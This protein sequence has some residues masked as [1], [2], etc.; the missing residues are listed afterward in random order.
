[1]T[2]TALMLREPA[3]PTSAVA[4]P[5]QAASDQQLIRLWLHGRPATTRRAYECDVGRFRAFVA[6]PLRMV[7]VGDVQEFSDSLARLADASRARS[8]SAVKSLLTF[9]CRIGYLPFNVGA[10]VRLPRLKNTIAER[11][12]PEEQVLKMLTLEAK[13]RNAALLRL[14]YGA[15]LRVSEL[16]A[17]RWRDVVERDDAAQITIYGK[18]SKTRFV[19]LTPATWGAL[20][21]IR[22]DSGPDDALIRSSRGDGAL[23]ARQ[24]RRIVAAAARRAGV[25]GNVSPHWLRHAHASHALDRGAAIHL[26]QATLGH[27]SVA[28]TGKYLHARPSESSSKYLAV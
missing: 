26:V 14:L 18:G 13:P 21:A 3:A 28:T 24:V 5:S 15:G 7:M 23:G 2:E 17:L 25:E 10:P 12:L 8:L 16:V 19:L 1:M 4:F 20:K 27:S 6:K 11:I 9:G 22:G